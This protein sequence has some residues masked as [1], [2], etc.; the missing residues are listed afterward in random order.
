MLLWQEGGRPR[1]ALIRR[2][3][4]G[5][6]L[7]ARPGLLRS[8]LPM[9]CGT[10]VLTVLIELVV[11][12][13]ERAFAAR[14]QEEHLVVATVQSGVLLYGVQDL[15]LHLWDAGEATAEE[16][17][18]VDILAV[19]VLVQ[20]G[21]HIFVRHTILGA[22]FAWRRVDPPRSRASPPMTY[23]VEK[24]IQL[25]GG[26]RNNHCQ[27]FCFDFQEED[28]LGRRVFIDEPQSHAKQ[29]VERETDQE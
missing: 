16:E 14:R 20:T 25:I 21:G 23:A 1:A 26:K 3:R 17:D 7:G 22:S 8:C 5:D 4:R 10:R 24:I 13:Q 27:T 11:R 18:Q 2:R 6:G 19:C 29:D 15:L 9:L 12:V 28:I